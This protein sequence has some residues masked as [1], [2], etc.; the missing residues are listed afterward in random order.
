MHYLSILP[1]LLSPALVAAQQ[2]AQEATVS[3]LVYGFPLVAFQQLE[4][5]RAM[6]KLPLNKFYHTRQLATASMRDVVAPNTDTIYSAA[7]VDLSHSDLE[8]TFPAVPDSQFMLVSFYDFYG[9]NYANLGTANSGKQGKYLVTKRTDITGNAFGRQP[10]ASSSSYVAE[11]RAPTTY[12]I[13]LIRT[14]VNATNLQAVYGYQNATTV[15]EI[16]F[17]SPRATEARLE[18]FPSSS[19]AANLIMNVLAKYGSIN[20]PQQLQKQAEIEAKLELAGVS[21][22]TYV[23]P[24]G[25]DLDAAISAAQKE[26]QGSARDLSNYRKLSNGW[27]VTRPGLAGNFDNG[28]VY[29]YRAAT[30]ANGYIM[31]SAPSAIYPSWDNVT[32]SSSNAVDSAFGSRS[33]NLGHDEA[34][35]YTF[36]GGR[37]PVEH[38]GFWS[39]TAYA[40]DGYLIPNDLNIYS[41]SERSNLTYSD[42]TPVYPR[43]GSSLSD[44][45][46]PFEILV[47]SADNP[48]PANWTSNWIPAPA[49]GGEVSPVLRA[50]VPKMQMIDGTYIYPVVTRRSAIVDSGAKVMPL[51]AVGGG[52]RVEVF[53]REMLL[54]AVL[55]TAT[56]ALAM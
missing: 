21:N 14:F 9:G 2:S 5:A 24:S 43:N 47:Q 39:L 17:A 29:D 11:F 30:A 20:P 13:I 48:P 54:A 38:N 4:T 3:G 28:T 44:T 12:G 19:S 46:R 41:L 18:A 1:W 33:L 7:V 40:P 22:G 27:K 42:G 6:L 55:A 56:W 8:L 37:P 36:V 45:S 52:G 34:V 50:Y 35:V 25:V 32:D 51:A 49:G 15:S 10:A 53:G 26:Y 23:T 31:L 16:P